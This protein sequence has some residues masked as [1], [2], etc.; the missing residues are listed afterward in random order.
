MKQVAVG[1]CICTN[2]RTRTP[3]STAGPRCLT[4]RHQYKN[5]CCHC[6]S[7]SAGQQDAFQAVAA[8]AVRSA[9]EWL[10]EHSS[11]SSTYLYDSSTYLYDALR[12]SE[13]LATLLR[14]L[15]CNKAVSNPKA[16]LQ[17]D[18]NCDLTV[19]QTDFEDHYPL[20][21][22]SRCAFGSRTTHMTVLLLFLL[23]VAPT[24]L[25]AAAD[26]NAL[27]L[28]CLVIRTY[29]GHGTYGDS[30]LINLLH[31]LKKQTHPR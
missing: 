21:T 23:A 1:A 29:Y 5:C 26:L 14:I 8:P 13:P 28:V 27:P 2:S 17:G 3:C 24:C 19:I 20:V 31:S 6:R 22:A 4:K 11:S 7:R 18:L 25:A 9:P 30:S 15:H 12:L 16:H 10:L